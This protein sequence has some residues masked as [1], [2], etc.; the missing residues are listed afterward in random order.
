MAALPDGRLIE[1]DCTMD[2][3][4]W[5]GQWP[6]SA[7]A[8]MKAECNLRIWDVDKGTVTNA[9]TGLPVVNIFNG[10]RCRHEQRWEPVYEQIIVL[11][12]QKVA[13]VAMDHVAILSYAPDPAHPDVDRLQAGPLILRPHLAASIEDDKGVIIQSRITSVVLLSTGRLAVSVGLE[14]VRYGRRSRDVA[15]LSYDALSIWDPITGVCEARWD[16]HDTAPI[17]PARLRQQQG[18]AQMVAY[19]DGR[20]MALVRAAPIE[21]LEEMDDDEDRDHD[22]DDEAADPG[23]GAQVMIFN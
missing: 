19:P 17:N 14:N 11:T 4:T 23:R 1:L 16:P 8:G 3:A 22:S 5:P 13:L 21:S 10:S 6:W 9:R 15:T 18:V 2:V 7:Q 20:I 12:F